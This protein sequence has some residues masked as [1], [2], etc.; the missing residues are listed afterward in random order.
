M[1]REQ[2][3][4]FAACAQRRQ[5]DRDDVEAVVE[6][7]AEAALADGLAKVD[8]GGGDDADVDLDLVDSAEVHEALVLEDAQDLGLGVQAHVADF[9]EEERAAVGDFEEPFLAAMA[10][11]KAPLTWPKRVD[12]S[13]SVGME[14]C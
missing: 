9:V 11:V 7:F 12:S 10:E 13:R 8:V 2:R 1:G 6:V 5:V 14:P 3:D 4:V